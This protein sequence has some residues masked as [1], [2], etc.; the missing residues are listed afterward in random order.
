MKTVVQFVSTGRRG[1]APEGGWRNKLY[2]R[3]LRKIGFVDNRHPKDGPY[4][5]NEEHWFVEI[6]RE[7]LSANGGGCFILKPLRLIPTEELMPLVVGMYEIATVDD[8]I[9]ITPHD[10]TKMWVMSPKA[11]EAILSSSSAASLVINHGGSLWPRRKP[12]ESLVEKEAK[13]LLSMASEPPEK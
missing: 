1:D 6:V 9:I 4:P 2:S 3:S 8:A 11:K 5:Q 13:K 7:N 12:A 10:H